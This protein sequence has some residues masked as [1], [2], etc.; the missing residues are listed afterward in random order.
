MVEAVPKPLPLRERKKIRTRQALVDT[1]LELFTARGF[2]GATLDDLCEAVEVSKRTFFRT[3]A[4]KE[5]VVTAPVQDLW[6]AFLRDLETREPEP[7]DTLL[8]MVS[9]SVLAGIEGMPDEGWARR[10]LLSRQLA[11]RTPSTE[12]H[13][14]HYCD[15]TSRAAMDLLHR[16]FDLGDAAGPRPR[17]VLDVV[18]AAFNHAVEAWAEGP[19][20]ATRERLLD[21]LRT[22]FAAIPGSLTLRAELR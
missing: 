11:A 5:D 17:L 20:E 19:G 15:R 3:F 8:G 6:E 12:A 9:S 22:A 7:G 10:M 2:D 21:E 14:L 13:C 4:G 18:V 16:R 1:A